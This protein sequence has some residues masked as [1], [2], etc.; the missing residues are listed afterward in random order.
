[1]NNVGYA[2]LARGQT[3]RALE[4]F[5]LNA[6]TYPDS[7][8]VHDSL[9]ECL[10]ADGKPR[11]ARDSYAR[12]VALGEKVKD[13]NLGFFRQHLEAAEARLKAPGR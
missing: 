4:A 7:P 11:E 13:P 3:A 5:R 9:G 10:E 6:A 12:A 1:M 8:N 2:E